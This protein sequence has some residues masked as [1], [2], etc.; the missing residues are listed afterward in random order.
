VK[1]LSR[2]LR[3]IFKSRR[4]KDYYTESLIA[5]RY[6][7]SY[8][9]HWII[10]KT[11]K[12]QSLTSAAEIVFRKRLI[13]GYPIEKLLFKINTP[14]RLFVHPEV[15][16]QVYHYNKSYL[17]NYEVKY[18]LL[19][20]NGKFCAGIYFLDGNNGFMDIKEAIKLKYLVAGNPDNDLKA[21]CFTDSLNNQLYFLETEFNTLL[22]HTI[23]GSFERLAHELDEKITLKNQLIEQQNM[24]QLIEEI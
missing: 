11:K 7:T 10:G 2:S 19:L 1:L 24:A 3:F 18:E 6:A 22:V 4:R 20:H 16:L 13:L 17:G 8:W 15:D 12:A 23:K 21:C 5:G 9:L 14:F